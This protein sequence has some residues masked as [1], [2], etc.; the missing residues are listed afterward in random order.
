M[1]LRFRRVL[2]VSALLSLLLAAW[3]GLLRLGWTL[4]PFPAADHGPLMISG[5]LGTLIALE[6]A[7]ALSA[8]FKHGS[9]AYAAPLL[10]A[11]GAAALVVGAPHAISIGLITLGSLGLVVIFLALVQRQFALFSVTMALG[12]LCWLL[13]NVLWLT[14]QPIYHLVEWWIAFLVLTIAGERLELTRIMRHSRASQIIFMG[15][16]AVYVVG[17]LLT[18]LQMNAG[19]L[20][21]GISL[22]ALGLWLFRY[23]I[24]RRTVKQAGLTR[25]IAFCLLAG[26]G[27]LLVGGAL[28]VGFGTQIAGL[29]YD[30]E[31]HSVL[32]GFVFSMIL[33]HAPIIL[34]A[35]LNVSMPFRQW[36]YVPLLLLHGSLILRIGADL[37]AA[38]VLRQWGGMF[39]VIAILL[40]LT[41]T[42]FTVYHA[43]A[44]KRTKR[45]Q[46]AVRSN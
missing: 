37:S 5:F 23:D 45:R 14:G 44:S 4:P 7:V 38:F 2:L 25:Y 6:R 11:L 24:A 18:T 40:F 19:T 43:E 3:A 32:L 29:F 31:L 10:S 15:I 8:S 46:E 26:Y 21:I 16:L 9:W 27:W 28:R 41:I 1:K 33:G 13:G 22:L 42:L 39:N 20:L 35:V 34:P 17:L 36:F 30:A 12:A